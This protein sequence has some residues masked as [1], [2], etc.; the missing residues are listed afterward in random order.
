MYQIGTN[1]EKWLNPQR[2]A[3]VGD[4]VLLKEK[5]ADRL[6][7][8]TG[9]IKAVTVDKDGLVRKVTVQ[10]HK[11]PGQSNYPQPRERAIHDLVLIKSFTAQDN[12]SPDCTTSRKAPEEA[13]T[14]FCSVSAAERELFVSDAREDLTPLTAKAENSS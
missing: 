2:N 14:L 4:E 6:E 11:R 1:K 12:P 5:S 10:P 9:V 7:W 3:Q 13:K 8:P